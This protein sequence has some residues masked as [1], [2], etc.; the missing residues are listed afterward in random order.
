[1]QDRGYVQE[2]GGQPHRQLWKMN[3]CENNSREKAQKTQKYGSPLALGIVGVHADFYPRLLII[4]DQSRL[5]FAATAIRS[6]KL[7]ESIAR[8]GL[9]GCATPDQGGT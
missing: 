7:G 3:G 8:A 2:L 9:T 4:F 6:V 1:M 5:T